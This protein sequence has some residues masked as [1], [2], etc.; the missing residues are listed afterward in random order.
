MLDQ[1]IS[2]IKDEISGKLQAEQGV[3]SDQIDGV[4]DVV[5]NVSQEKIGGEL[6]GGNLDSVMNLFSDKPNTQEADSLQ[7]NL[8]SGIMEGL[9][10]KLGLDRSKASSI[11]NTVAPIL[12]GFLTKKNNETA[13]DDTSPLTNLFGGGDLGNIAKKTLG[14]LF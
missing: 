3:S 11:V 8:T 9:I 6:L 12:I 5:S 7:T 10:G 2:G 1:L 14:G 4:M 13:D